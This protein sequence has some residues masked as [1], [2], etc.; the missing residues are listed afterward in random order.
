[1]VQDAQGGFRVHQRDREGPPASGYGLGTGLFGFALL[2]AL[3]ALFSNGLHNL[4]E[5]PVTRAVMD[6]LRRRRSPGRLAIV[7]DQS[8]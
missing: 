4:L 8:A 2:F 1:M 7:I 6:R 5:V 3:T